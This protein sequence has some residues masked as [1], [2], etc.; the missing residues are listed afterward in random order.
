MIGKNDIDVEATRKVCNTCGNYEWRGLTKW[1][2]S[3][4]AP[5]GELWETGCD[6]YRYVYK[7][8]K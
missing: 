6:Q 7:K 2:C 4:G 3:A 1:C 8:G 5:I